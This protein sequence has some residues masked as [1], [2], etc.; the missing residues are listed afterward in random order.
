LQRNRIAQLVL[1]EVDEFDLAV[2]VGVC[3]AQQYVSLFTL[4]VGQGERR[5]AVHLDVTV[6]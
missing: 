5:V 6:E 1:V 2:A 4:V 3:L